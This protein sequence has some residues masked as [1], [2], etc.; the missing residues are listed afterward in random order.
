M[1]L[2]S[3]LKTI[4]RTYV[5]LLLIVF[6]V[7]SYG[8]ANRA[9][10]QPLAARVQA[11]RSEINKTPTT[12]SNFQARLDTLV[13]WGND[14]ASRGRFTPQIMPVSF[15]RLQISG[16][17]PEAQRSLAQLVKILGFIED[18]GGRTG[19]LV[20]TDRNELVAGEY[21]TVTLE[22][23][24][25][26][27]EATTGAV[28]R[29]GH[30]FMADGAALQTT[31]PQG[32][33]FVSFK[34]ASPNV[35]LEA[36]TSQ[37]LSSYGGFRAPAA[38]PAVK[39]TSGSL[40]QGDKLIITI[41]DRTQGS[42]G[43]QLQTRDADEFRY[44]LE[45]DQEG[46]GVFVPVG[47]L[48]T[49]I[50]G[51]VAAAINAVVPST[52]ATGER[53]ALRLRVEDQY[54]NPAQFGGGS[55]QVKLDGKLLGT[56]KVAAGDYTA[57]L[58]NLKLD[59][60]GAY[61]FEVT[62]SD[63]KFKTLSNPLLVERTP[64]QRIYWGELH[65][66]SGWEEG[67]G[68]MPHYYHY[69]R[70]VA[71]LDF[72]ALTAHDAMLVKPAWDEWRRETQKAKRPG[73]FVSFMGYEWTVSYDQGGHH[74]V[75]FKDDHGRYV[76]LRE[77]P[78]LP[79]LYEKLRALDSPDNILVIPHAHQPGDWNFND[80]EIER[81]AEIFSIHG[82]FEYFGQRYLRRYRMGVVGASDNHTG[83][84]GYSPAQT[85]TRN[86]LAA[87]YA[88][89]LDRDSI[90]QG[91]KGAATY[92]TSNAQRMVVKMNLD[93]KTVGQFIPTG[94][95]PTLQ[96]RVLG[97]TPIERIDV[98]HNG[99]VEFSQEYLQPVAGQP[100]TVQ[101]MLWSPTETP[102]DQVTFPL[103]GVT[104]R[105]WIEVQNGRIGS[106][107]GLGMD[108]FSDHFE[109]TDR[110][111]VWFTCK[112]RGDYDGVLLRLAE[113]SANTKVIVRLD[114][115]ER[116]QGP[117][118]MGLP[119]QLKRPGNRSLHEFSFSV[120]E[121]LQKK[122]TFAVP[123][124]GFVSARRLSAEGKWDVVFRYR[125]TNTPAQDDFYMLRIIQLDGETAWTSPIW[126]GAPQTAR[127]GTR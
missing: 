36:T 87:V 27:V 17:T 64:R 33:S 86:G 72:G 113:S 111:R 89:R 93:D 41:G 50:K 31:N 44:P 96:A 101:L 108:H 38:M 66:H 18:H 60:E 28:F 47:V 12:A 71:F 100:A 117:Q 54:L 80:P 16:F 3:A 59:R 53:F 77:A 14:L 79:L 112:T 115:V 99:T 92:T 22:Y 119:R 85:S 91:L 65:G 126:I 84:P 83:H 24:V 116:D 81:L 55:F 102:G 6:A 57:R 58:D 88:P 52:V 76:T 98:L 95:T 103:N 46:Q 42:R 124:F 34:T 10:T 107:E 13:D 8:I 121:L 15:T 19:S 5:L 62:S 43:Y 25:G 56:L 49:R 26:E 70:D 67:T 40:R 61:K 74:N 23:T 30:H 11:L 35:T 75:F 9:Q 1:K 94:T 82:S 7:V 125:P 68:S 48:A 127:K 4:P 73:S 106:L 51:N 90:W 69:A 109:Q 118:G 63:G 122:A 104:W 21:A 97:T 2:L 114:T 105:G 39:L 120:E 78:R 110:Q 123:Q 37:W 45:L 32:D 20:R 29:L